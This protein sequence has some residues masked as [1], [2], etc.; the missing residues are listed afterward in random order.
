MLDA[1]RSRDALRDRPV[2]WAD[3]SGTAGGV[4]EHGNL[5]VFTDDGERLTLDAGEVH[6][7]R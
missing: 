5:V 7:E 6:L 1:Y 3:G 4:D 2:S